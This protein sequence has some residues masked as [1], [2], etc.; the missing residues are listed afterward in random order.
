M[1]EYKL[2]KSNNRGARYPFTIVRSYPG[3]FNYYYCTQA[4][5]DEYKDDLPKLYEVSRKN[6]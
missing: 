3:F 4:D 5:V 2:V 6:G 1:I